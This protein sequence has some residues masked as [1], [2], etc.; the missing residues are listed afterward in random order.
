MTSWAWAGGRI[1]CNGTDIW[2]IFPFAII[3]GHQRLSRPRVPLD[4]RENSGSAHYVYRM[5]QVLKRKTYTLIGVH[6]AEC[7]SSCVLRGWEKTERSQGQI[8][9]KVSM[10]LDGLGWV[11]E[12]WRCAQCE[13]ERIWILCGCVCFRLGSMTEVIYLCRDRLSLKTWVP[14]LKE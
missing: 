14:L 10:A 8:Y 4:G 11:A 5:L 12:D 9:I 6:F 7:I 13:R 2:G 1:V 3:L